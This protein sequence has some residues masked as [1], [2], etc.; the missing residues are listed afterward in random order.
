MI[1]EIRRHLRLHDALIAIAESGETQQV[2]IPED[3][4]AQY[5]QK[6]A[7]MLATRWGLK[8][9]TRVLD[10]WML[11]GKRRVRPEVHE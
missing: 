3:K 5:Y 2:A 4:E 1:G 11:I 7:H 6:Y 8:I 9:A 10:G